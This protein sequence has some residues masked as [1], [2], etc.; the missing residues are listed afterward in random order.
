VHEK[1]TILNV[2]AHSVFTG[3]GIV[4]PVVALL[5]T[6]N[7]KKIAVK[8]AFVLTAVQVLRVAGI[9][10]FILWLADTYIAMESLQGVNAIDTSN[11]LFGTYSFA[12]WF[13]PLMYLLLSQLF[14]IKKL[15][16]KKAPLITLALMLL[17]LPSQR[18]L[19]IITSF[20]RDYLPSSW[21]MYQGSIVLQ[22]VLNIIVFIFIVFTVMLAG[23]KLKKVQ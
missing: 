1:F 7:L 3:F 12:Y 18:L 22:V 20:H 4:I 2:L 14:W 19:I 15:Y 23:G 10:Y 8:E 5:R 16:I 9:L 21:V 6:S 11:R 13:S 17:I